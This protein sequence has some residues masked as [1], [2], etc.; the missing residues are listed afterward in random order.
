MPALTKTTKALKL[1]KFEELLLSGK[2]QAEI[3][4]ALGVSPRQVRRWCKVRDDE[5]AADSNSYTAA[6]RSA[7]LS[8]LGRILEEAIR[9]SGTARGDGRHTHGYL[10][11]RIDALRFI[12]EAACSNH[13]VGLAKRARK[14][15]VEANLK[16]QAGRLGRGDGAVACS[17]TADRCDLKSKAHEWQITFLGI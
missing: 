6:Y 3:A 16:R 10:N 7:I 2:T 11:V 9:D 15:A 8:E 14:A 12:P 4:E 17:E 5:L 13:V 1:Q